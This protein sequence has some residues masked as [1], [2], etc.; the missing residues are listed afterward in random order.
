ME[1]TNKS[2]LRHLG[3]TDILV[4]PIGLG[5]MELAGGGRLMGR[6]YPIIPQEEKNAIIKAALDGGINWFDTAEMYGFGVSEQSLV[7]GLKAAGKSDK[8]VV[9][10][11]K[12]LPY[13]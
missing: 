9:I 3:K 6:I 12:W 1:M 7:A 2:Q 8:E 4:T 5:V 11:T 13:L 10:A